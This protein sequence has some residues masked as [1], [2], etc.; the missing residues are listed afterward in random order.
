MDVCSVFTFIAQRVYCSFKMNLCNRLNGIKC[1][2]IS[3][4]SVWYR[5]RDKCPGMKETHTDIKYFLV[6]HKHTFSNFPQ[7]LS[8]LRIFI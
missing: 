6:C 8:K 3:V 7:N 5:C 2:M 4:G 1:C